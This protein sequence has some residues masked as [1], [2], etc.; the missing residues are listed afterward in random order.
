MISKFSSKKHESL[1]FIRFIQQE[2]NQ[3]LFYKK[4]GFFPVLNSIYK[5]S[6]FIRENPE[7]KYCADLLKTGRHR[8][9]R[10]DYTQISDILSYYFKLILKNQMS[11]DEAINNSAM[12]INS[13]QAFIY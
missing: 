9:F 4:S 2:Q 1:E 3:I 12:K 10:E 13:D 6:E 11:I 8:P 5:N 7:I